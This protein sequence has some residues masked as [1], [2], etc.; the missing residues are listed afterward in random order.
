MGKE[1]ERNYCNYVQDG[2]TWLW[3]TRPSRKNNSIEERECVI[4]CSGNDQC[5][6]KQTHGWAGRG[7]EGAKPKEHC[8][9]CIN[10]LSCEE[11]CY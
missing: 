5:I 8:P 9:I 10:N 1:T 11:A 3:R 2:V 7:L 6:K 4:S